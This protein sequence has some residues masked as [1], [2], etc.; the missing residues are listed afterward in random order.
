MVTTK[1][2][3]TSSGMD[4]PDWAYKAM[5]DCLLPIIQQYYATEEGKRRFAEWK[6]KQQANKGEALNASPLSHIWMS[7]MNL[8][9]PNPSP[10]G[11]SLGFG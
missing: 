5:A 9:K 11:I 6:S 2:K 3:K 1:V 4:I 7:L 8:T 10:M